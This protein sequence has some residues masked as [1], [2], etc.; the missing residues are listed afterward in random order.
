MAEFSLHIRLDAEDHDAGDATEI[1]EPYTDEYASVSLGEAKINNPDAPEILA[2]E[3]CL[4]IDDVD[5]FAEIYQALASD[6]AVHDVSL[7]G[8]TAER[9]PLRVEHYALQHLSTP[10]SYE[11]YAL[12][13]QVTMVIAD[14]ERAYRRAKDEVPAGARR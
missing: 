14:S 5:A 12:D 6:A 3:T 9:Y 8:P 1:L 7:W 11:F 13:N 4:E 2:P 10:D